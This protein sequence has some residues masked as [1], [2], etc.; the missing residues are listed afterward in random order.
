VLSSCDG[1]EVTPSYLCR[2]YKTFAYVPAAT[3]KNVMGFL[4]EYPSQAD[5]QTFMTEY[6]TDAE[7]V[8]FTHHRADQ[9]G[10]VRPEPPRRGGEPEHPVRLGR[11]VPDSAHLLQ[12]RWLFEMVDR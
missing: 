11:G 6:R 5:L 1:D 4:K 2:L 12:H 10:R 7:D 9:R 8:T 3:D